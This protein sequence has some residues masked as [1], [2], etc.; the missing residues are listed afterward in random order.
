[1]SVRAKENVFSR[2]C[3]CVMCMC[4]HVCMHVYVSKCVYVV[5]AGMNPS[6]RVAVEQTVNQMAQVTMAIMIT[7]GTKNE[8]IRSAK[9][10]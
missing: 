2:V 5:P 10:C 8:E 7:T 3:V 9:A 6:G 4:E 1:M